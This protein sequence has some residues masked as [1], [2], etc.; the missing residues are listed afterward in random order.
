[1]KQINLIA[2]FILI[3]VIIT[4]CGQQHNTQ[5]A[6]NKEEETHQHEEEI[7]LTDLQMKAVDIRLGNIEM[8]DLNNIVRVNGEL[9]LDPQKEAEVTSLTSGIVKQ[10][11]VTEGKFVTAGQAVAYLENIEIVE[12]QSKYLVLKKETM[13]AEQEYNRQRELAEQDAGIEKILQQAAAT[14]EITK[15]QLTALDQQLRQLAI[16]PEQ[17]SAGNIATQ[18][19]LRA[20]IAGYVNKIDVKTGSFVDTQTPLMHIT[21]NTGIHCDVKI[22]EKDV[23]LVQIGQEVN[24]RLTNRQTE[25]LKGKVYDIN[26]SFDD[27]SKAIAVHIALEKNATR[28]QLIPG[29]YVTG[30]INTGRQKTAAVPNDAIVSNNGKKFIF[31]HEHDD[32]EADGREKKRHF[33]PIEVLTGVSESGYTQITPIKNLDENTP[34]V[35]SNAFYLGSMRADHGEHNH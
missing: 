6:T 33:L 23:P 15:V 28:A 25:T 1:M 18:I 12:L 14:H 17:V 8:R 22:F 31:V 34:V 2:A 11:L 19:P 10:V 9:A 27:D 3:S 30:F 20:P 7:A 26:R 21:D 5:T 32:E 13:M 24:L 4:A 29:M 16:S 35:I